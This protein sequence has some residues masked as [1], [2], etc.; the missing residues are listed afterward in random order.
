MRELAEPSDLIGRLAELRQQLDASNPQLYRHL[1]LYLQV[2]RQDLPAAVDQACFHLA[3]QVHPDRYA[4]LPSLS[5][6]QLHMRLDQLVRRCTSLLTVEQLSHLAARLSAEQQHQMQLKRLRWLQDLGRGTPAGPPTADEPV[7]PGRS[8][9]RGPLPEGSVEL[10]FDLPLGQGGAGWI[11]PTPG[12]EEMGDAPEHDDEDD[13]LL[14]DPLQPFSSDDATAGDRNHNDASGL[15]RL[16]AAFREEG[17]LQDS[18]GLFATGSPPPP[19]HDEPSDDDGSSVESDEDLD[20]W[21]S[22]LT[23]AAS[24]LAAPTLPG[25]WQDGTLPRDPSQLL[26]WLEGFERALTR[27]LRDL[28][29][30]VNGLLLRHGLSSSL[31]PVSLLDAVLSG[32]IDSQAAPPNLLRLQLPLLGDAGGPQLHSHA[33]L[34][35]RADLEAENPRLRTCRR[36][37]HQH[38]QELRRMAGLYVRLQRHLRVQEAASLW[39]QDIQRHRPGSP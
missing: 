20:G 33:L 21:P 17:R 37:L 14:E 25:P 38:L 18:I 6:A 13:D 34:L 28:S 3:T 2:L 19:G 30:S 23:G 31:L 9:P 36:R 32:R 22:A 4:A 16:V 1:A 29:H 39:L 26:L 12:P 8:M 24:D 15:E 5:R 10:G 7:Q 35:R 11:W 27:R